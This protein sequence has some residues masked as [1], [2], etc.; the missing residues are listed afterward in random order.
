MEVA[1]LDHLEWE[2]GGGGCF[3]FILVREGFGEKLPFEEPF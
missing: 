3:A 2:S 1:Y